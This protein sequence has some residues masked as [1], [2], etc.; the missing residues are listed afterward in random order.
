MERCSAYPWGGGALHAPGME[1]KHLSR[2]FT[3]RVLHVMYCFRD[4]SGE[5]RLKSPRMNLGEAGE[6][7]SIHCG[8]HVGHVFSGSVSASSGATCTSMRQL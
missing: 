6:K 3:R 2:V 8:H 5:Q 4:L 7:C 1:P